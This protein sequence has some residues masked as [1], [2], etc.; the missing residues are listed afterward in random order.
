MKKQS[1]EEGRE[2]VGFL[3]AKGVEG[4]PIKRVLFS[5]EEEAKAW[6]KAKEATGKYVAV[7]EYNNGRYTESLMTFNEFQN[8]VNESK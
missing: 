1:F 6:V 4:E 2:C 8:K 5:S 7:W 3:Y